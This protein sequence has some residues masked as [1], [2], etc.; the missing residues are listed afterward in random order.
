M[1][2]FKIAHPRFGF[3]AHPCTL[4]SHLLVLSVLLESN[5]RPTSNCRNDLGPL[6]TLPL[7]SYGN[8]MTAEH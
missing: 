5:Y 1:L 6:C 7:G 4:F 3:L 2:L 8:C